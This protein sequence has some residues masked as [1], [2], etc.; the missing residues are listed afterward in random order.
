MRLYHGNTNIIYGFTISGSVGTLKRTVMLELIG[1][2]YAIEL[3]T[4][5]DKTVMEATVGLVYSVEPYGYVNFYKYPEGG[6]PTKTLT[7][8][9]DTAPGSVAVSLAPK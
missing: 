9:D 4:I 2:Q 7:V 1:K 3:P 6:S 8:G 5:F